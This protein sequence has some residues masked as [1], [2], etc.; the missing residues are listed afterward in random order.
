MTD[1]P[2]SRSG[3]AVPDAPPSPP[4]EDPWW[5]TADF[6]YALP[7]DLIAQHPVAERSGSRLLHVRPDGLADRGFRELPQLLA[8]GDIMVF[9]D[10]RVLK[11]RLSG[12]KPSGGRVELLLERVLGP[13]AARFQLRASHPPHPGGVVELP[14]DIRATVVARDGR[15]VDLAFAGA[16]SIT[17]YLDR[18]GTTPLPPYIQRPADAGDDARYQTVYARKPGAVAAP[19]A[20]LHFDDATLAA[21][22]A[23]GVARSFVTLHVGAATFAPVETE[24]LRTHRMHGERFEIPPAT[25]A[26]I[27]AARRQGGRV[28]AVGTTTLRAL[29][30]AADEAGEVASGDAETDLF[31]TSGLSLPR[32]RPPAHQLPPAALDSAHAG[33]GVRRRRAHARRLCPRHRGTLSLLQLR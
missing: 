21:I 28:L 8:P 7:A 29:E 17:D 1:A 3:R 25:A 31:I 5:R 27:G 33:V 16:A 26:A 10:T 30:A 15:F 19:T 9:N 20:G 14:G 23:R 11:S 18:F 4:E 22:D 24:D 32:R 6:D 12:R 2:A 13:G